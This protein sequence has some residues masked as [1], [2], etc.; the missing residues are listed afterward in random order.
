MESCYPEIKKY[1]RFLFAK[2]N[3]TIVTKKI[4]TF[5]SKHN[6]K[7]SINEL[8]IKIFSKITGLENILTFTKKENEKKLH[9]IIFNYKKNHFK[10]ELL[11]KRNNDNTDIIKYILFLLSVFYQLSIKSFNEIFLN[12]EYSLLIEK[13]FLFCIK[14]YNSQLISF[15][16]IINIYEYFLDVILN[17]EFT[18][19]ITS[20]YVLFANLIYKFFK[21]SENINEDCNE[22]IKLLLMKY[23]SVI[24]DSNNFCNNNMKF[25]FNVCNYSDILKLINILYNENSFLSSEN[26]NII[27]ANLSKLLC[28][29]FSN[30][31]TKYFY[32]LI[33][34]F[35]RK[36]NNKNSKENSYIK[37]IS[38]FNE[39]INLFSDIYNNEI[40]QQKN[41]YFYFKTN[42]GFFFNSSSNY[43]GFKT[44]SIKFDDQYGLCIMFSFYAIQN[45]SNNEDEQDILTVKN[46]KND[47]N[48]LA[49]VLIGESLYVNIYKNNKKEE[50]LFLK[51]IEF[52]KNYFLILYYDYKSI[53][54]YI[55]E[56]KINSDLQL[57]LKKDNKIFIE[58]GSSDQSSKFSFKNRFNGIIGSVL[59]FNSI[60]FDYCNIF[61]NIIKNLQNNYYLLGEFF[62]DKQ[63]SEITY[64]SSY[65]EYHGIFN[66]N[67]QKNIFQIIKVI[68]KNLGKLILNL[69]PNVI[70]N[71]FNH[72]NKFF[73]RD[74]QNA[75]NEIYYIFNK[76]PNLDKSCVYA[77]QKKNFFYFFTINYGFNFIVL[78]VEYI[79]NYLLIK[80]EIN[81]VEINKM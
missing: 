29:N 75:K 72:S 46:E 32:S 13:L 57:Y 60:I 79:Y 5:L 65:E 48:L 19:I 34:K 30:E 21:L 68:R 47:E 37:N 18:L 40:T 39:I 52:N 35:I 26:K 2:S 23:F 63:I 55:N 74:F 17:N 81:E 28:Y 4:N 31:H 54:V 50:N 41:D 3:L 45:N 64:R 36:F 53:T 80:T 73:Y 62:N 67:E 27:K 49:F 43:S 16:N 20:L 71:N 22:K 42:N 6:I 7:C 59:I 10:K 38:L 56:D 66:C 11:Y 25:L 14:L 33:N 12:E 24:G 77:F 51:S 58:I 70:I 1:C 61:E 8:E 9:I 78:L 69:N 15:E 76:E 44:T